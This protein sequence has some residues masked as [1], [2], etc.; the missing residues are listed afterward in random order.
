MVESN[1]AFEGKVLEV[2]ELSCRTLACVRALFIIVVAD[3]P[4]NTYTRWN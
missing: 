3:L 1:D 2:L 4:L